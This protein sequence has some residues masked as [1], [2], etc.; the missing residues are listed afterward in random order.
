MVSLNASLLQCCYIIH[1][2]L[3]RTGRKQSLLTLKCTFGWKIF[4]LKRTVGGTSGYCSGTLM[5]SSLSYAVMLAAG[6]L[7]LPGPHKQLEVSSSHW[8]QAMM[9]HLEVHVWVED[10]CSEAHDWRHQ[11]VLLWH[12]DGKLKR[13]SFKRRLCGPLQ[14]HTTQKNQWA[15]SQFTY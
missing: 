1:K 12:V 4:I 5:D 6:Q 9:T 15:C 10:L 2:H 13:A 3:D 8:L 11:R 14:F 7:Q